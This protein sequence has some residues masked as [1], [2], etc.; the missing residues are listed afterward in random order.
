MKGIGF[1]QEERSPFKKGYGNV[2]ILKVALLLKS[3]YSFPSFTK[4][5]ES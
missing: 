5:Y 4:P 1:T 2:L 3:K